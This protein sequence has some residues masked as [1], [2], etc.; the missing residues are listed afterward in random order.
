MQKVHIPFDGFGKNTK[1]AAEIIGQHLKC[2]ER[3]SIMF[4]V[5]AQWAWDVNNLIHP[6]F[7][8]LNLL[9]RDDSITRNYNVA[10]YTSREEMGI[11]AFPC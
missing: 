3:E 1:E 6:N 5:P 7:G 2:R 9:R 4:I 11:T 8:L 10:C